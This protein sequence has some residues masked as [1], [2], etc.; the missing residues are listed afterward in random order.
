MLRNAERW[1][2][3]LTRLQQPCFA[4]LYDKYK[5]NPNE[6]LFVQIKCITL[7]KYG[8]MPM[9]NPLFVLSSSGLAIEAN[10]NNFA[11]ILILL[12]GVR[13]RRQHWCLLSILIL[14]VVLCIAIGLPISSEAWPPSTPEARMAVVKQLLKEA[15]LIDG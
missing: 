3:A 2:H 8:A 12:S 6:S 7:D 14:I 11:T 9:A 15:P 4:S 5:K 13:F 10:L 1:K